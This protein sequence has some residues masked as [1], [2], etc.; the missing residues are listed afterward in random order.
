MKKALIVLLALLS[1]VLI[2]SCDNKTKT[3]EVSAALV[4]DKTTVTWN[5]DGKVKDTT[6]TVKLENAYFDS[7]LFSLST[8][9]DIAAEFFTSGDGS[10][11]KN[12]GLSFT[13]ANGEG[14]TEKSHT[15]K[16][17]IK[18]SGTAS[19]AVNSVISGNYSLTIPSKYLKDD[20]AAVP[21]SGVTVKDAVGFNLLL[22][23]G[24]TNVASTKYGNYDI[25]Y[26]T[27]QGWAA[28]TI[29]LTL[30]NCTSTLSETGEPI[31]VEYDC[32]TA[33]YTL[34]GITCTATY[35]PKTDS[36]AATIKLVF[37]GNPHYSDNNPNTAYRTGAVCI[38]VDSLK[39]VADTDCTLAT[40][41]I[42]YGAFRIQSH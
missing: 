32:S 4:G 35:T 21:T 9:S 42:I 5:T 24:I 37:S 29:T 10:T 7:S 23:A 15:L 30:K 28:S 19:T 34:S 36:A 11:L 27:T 3:P 39:L 17:T 14:E 22:P 33:E 25:C 16:I 26:D 12:K 38:S 2:A 31:S 8:S 40:T 41:P 1:L 20:G 18:D 6:V 13:I